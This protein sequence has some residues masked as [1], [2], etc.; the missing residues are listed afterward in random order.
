MSAAA[1]AVTAVM[2]MMMMMMMMFQM[3]RNGCLTLGYFNLPR[4]VVSNFLLHSAYLF[5][6][7]F[8]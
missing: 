5:Y 6:N 3:I 4:D 1:D 8:S 7:L 2:M